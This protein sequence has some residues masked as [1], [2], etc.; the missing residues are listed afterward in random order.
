ME[1]YTALKEIAEK[2]Q[3]LLQNVENYRKEWSKSLKKTIIREL[4]VLMKAIEI[5]GEISEEE[6]VKGLEVVAL[7][8]GKG[9]SGI[10]EQIN[11]DEKQDFF[12][13]R[14]A[15][16]FSQLFNGKVQ[17]WMTYPL[18][19]GLM[20]PRPPRLLGIF[21]PP[22]FNNELILN[23]VDKFLRE[24]IQWEDYDDDEPAE[25]RASIGFGGA[26]GL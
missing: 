23:Q 7:R 3:T 13:D 20:E 9:R 26:H 11:K 6:K 21:A 24:L 2:Y 25:K 17:V 19:E 14:G 5:D 16:M 8:L 15:L 1:K 10:Y 4:K 12:K 22:E 18:I